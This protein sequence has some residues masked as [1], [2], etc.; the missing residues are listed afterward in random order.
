[1]GRPVSRDPGIVPV[2]LTLFGICLSPFIGIVLVV[3]AIGAFGW[4]RDGWR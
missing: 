2:A 3:V 1:M 4:I